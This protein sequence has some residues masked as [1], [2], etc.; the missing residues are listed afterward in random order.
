MTVNKVDLQTLDTMIDEIIAEEFQAATAERKQLNEGILPSFNEPLYDPILLSAPEEGSREW[1]RCFIV[2]T[3]RKIRFNQ[4]KNK[5]INQQ[6]ELLKTDP[7]IAAEWKS[8]V[9]E[10]NRRMLMNDLGGYAA[11]DIANDRQRNIMALGL[12]VE[13]YEEMMDSQEDYVNAAKEIYLSKDLTLWDEL[14]ATSPKLF[15]SIEAIYQLN[16][17]EQDPQAASP[18]YVKNAPWDGEE[19]QLST[20]HDD[21]GTKPLYD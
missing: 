6:I 16:F 4:N 19:V 2:E 14:Y 5:F 3:T 12:A 13:G 17:K 18:D 11:W 10:L 21:R 7:G 8:K 20:P 9:M 15:D 1:L